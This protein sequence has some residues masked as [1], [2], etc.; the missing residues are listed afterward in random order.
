MLRAYVSV[1]VRGAGDGVGT[2]ADKAAMMATGARGEGG[3]LAEMRVAEERVGP[4]LN[5]SNC[6]RPAGRCRVQKTPRPPRFWPACRVPPYGAW[7]RGGWRLVRRCVR[8]AIKAPAAA[9][10]R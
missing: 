2:A 6:V 9:A 10:Q 8:E 3:S 7:R 1:R 5:R 4:N